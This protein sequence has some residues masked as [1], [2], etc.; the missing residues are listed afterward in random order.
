MYLLDL[1]YGCLL[2]IIKRKRNKYI[3]VALI[4]FNHKKIILQKTKL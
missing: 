2:Q 1:Q 4:L 3:S